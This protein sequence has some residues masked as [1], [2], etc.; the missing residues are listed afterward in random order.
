MG[1][2]SG[3]IHSKSLICRTDNFALY[4]E[5]PFKNEFWKGHSDYKSEIRMV[6]AR[7]VKRELK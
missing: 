3:T 2:L 4:F 7:P 1:E 5:E 6:A